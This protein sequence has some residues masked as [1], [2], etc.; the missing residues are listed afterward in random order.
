MT[1]VDIKEIIAVQ[2]K[3]QCL[4]TVQAVDQHIEHVAERINRA[5]QSLNPIVICIMTG[6][7][8]FCGKLLPLLNFP[9]QFDYAHATRY[10][11]GTE[12]STLT[13]RMMPAS[14]LQGR[15]V[16]IIDD[17]YDVGETLSGVIDTCKKLGALSVKSAVL[18][19]KHHERKHNSEFIVD[20]VALETSDC[21]LFGY[22]MDYK[23]Y[24]RNA[25][26]IF[27]VTQD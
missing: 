21:Y 23:G 19:N 24:L 25:P 3:A 9:M 5:Y 18:V 7:V 6:G 27:A 10:N 26:G 16:L 17:I 15:H 8:V 2:E 13:W 20:F 12:G 14:D 11:S 4:Y 22:G 1:K